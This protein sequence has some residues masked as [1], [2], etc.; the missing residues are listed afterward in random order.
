MHIY[1]AQKTAS[2]YHRFSAWKE[3]ETI[4]NELHNYTGNSTAQN[5]NNLTVPGIITPK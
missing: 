4:F 5:S 1:L 3:C 2:G